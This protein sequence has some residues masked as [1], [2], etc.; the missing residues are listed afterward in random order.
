MLIHEL[1]PAQC[2]EVLGRTTIARLA[3]A[4]ADQ[5]Y[6]VPV[7]LAFDAASDYLFGFSS[8]GRKVDWM[9]ENPLVCVEVE[10]VVDRFHWTTVVILGRY[11]EITDAADQG[12]IRQRALDLFAQ[13]VEWW[14]PAAARVEPNEHHAVLLY[15]IRIETITGRRAARDR[16]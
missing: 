16:G 6:V 10:D 13:R 14:L 4:R 7:S 8:V 2:R 11:E 3:C 1:T 9:R 12:P 15:R 5:P